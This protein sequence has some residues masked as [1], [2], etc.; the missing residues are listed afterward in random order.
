VSA[1]HVDP[2]ARTFAF[3][4][5]KKMYGG[6][7]TAIALMAFAI[8][9]LSAGSAAAAISEYWPCSRHRLLWPKSVPNAPLYFCV[10]R[11]ESRRSYAET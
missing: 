2:R 6:K 9:A 8:F 5:H 11:L 3:T 10:D 1:Q 4:A 7:L